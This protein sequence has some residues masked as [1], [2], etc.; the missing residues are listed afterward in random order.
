MELFRGGG[1][2]DKM[3]FAVADKFSFGKLQKCDPFG[4]GRV[5]TD[6]FVSE[7]ASDEVSAGTTHDASQQDSRRLE[8]HVRKCFLVAPIMQ[9]A[10][11]RAEFNRGIGEFGIDGEAT[12]TAAHDPRDPSEG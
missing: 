5:G 2:D 12:R 9:H 6:C 7:V 3:L 11:S 4:G 8:M 10:G 1:F